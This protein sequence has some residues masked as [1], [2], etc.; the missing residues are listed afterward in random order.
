MLKTINTDSRKIFA[1]HLSVTQILEIDFIF[2]RY[3]H[4]NEREY[5]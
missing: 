5:E 4:P 1:L 2:V 3:F